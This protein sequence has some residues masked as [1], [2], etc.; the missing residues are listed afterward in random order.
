[1][2][3]NSKMTAIADG[4]R[5][6]TSLSDTLTLDQ[7]AIDILNLSPLAVGEVP[8]YVKSETERVASIVKALQNENTITTIHASDV[9]VGSDNQSRTSALHLAQGINLLKRLIPID[10]VFLHGDIV[11]G[12]SNDS[13]ETH[14]NNHVYARKMIAIA[15]FDL[16]LGGNHDANIY[17]SESYM[18]ASEIY[19]YIGRRNVKVVKPTTETDF[20][21]KIRLKYSHEEAE[22]CYEVRYKDL[23]YAIAKACTETLKKFG[24][25][26]YHHST[27]EE[28]IP[29]RYFLFLK[30]V[31]LDR[32]DLL[33]LDNVEE[34][35]FAVTS[36]FE[37]EM[38]L[39]LFDM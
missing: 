36:S 27:Y 15:D 31:A 25:L 22:R 8:H 5:S 9:H 7:M 11:T 6:K 13:L 28:D 26:G 30:A 34:E 2:S 17:N 38:E 16:E 3:V 14:L 35:R 33:K 24:I 39:L 32:L 12:A 20:N 18:S 19:K 1:M 10:G 23:C 29:L 37:K 21:I 4:I